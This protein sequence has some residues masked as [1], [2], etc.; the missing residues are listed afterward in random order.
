MDELIE[1][2]KREEFTEIKYISSLNPP[3]KEQVDDFMLESK[4]LS[5]SDK[6]NH[7]IEINLTDEL[8]TKKEVCLVVTGSVDSGKCFKLGTQVM[9]YNGIIEKVE[10]LKIGDLLM[11]DDSTPRKIL[12][13]HKGMGQLYK[14]I[15]F[16]GKEYVVNGE[17]ILCLRYKELNK[18]EFLE[19][20]NI[21]E[22]SVKEFLKLKK[23]E[24][25][26]LKW[27]KTDIEFPKKDVPFEAYK[28]GILLGNS[29][30]IK[31]KGIINSE[32]K[33]KNIPDIYKYNSKE[34]RLKL[35]AGLIDSD[36]YYNK[37]KNKYSFSILSKYKKLINDTIWLIRS[38]GLSIY[39]YN[40]K[41]I[42]I[43]TKNGFI[44]MSY[45]QFDFGGEKQETI[46]CMLFRKRAFKRINKKSNLESKI[47]IKKVEIGEYIGFSLDRNKRFLLEDFSVSHNSSFIGVITSGELDDGKG[48]ARAKVAKH[49]HEVKEGKTS[50]I[51]T[52]TI[53]LNGNIV[54][55]V[56]LC[57]HEKYL[58]TTL[59]GITGFYPDYGVLI[60]SANRGLLRMT[61][62][63]M[64]ILLYLKIPFIILITRIDIT[65]KNIYE[66]VLQN[67]SKILRKFK[68]EPEIINSL[69]DLD[70]N[71]D[72]LKE[73][74][75]ECFNLTEKIAKRMKTNHFIVPIITIS[76]KTGYFVEVVKHI[77]S[78][79][80]SRKI[81]NSISNGSIF[82]IDSKF[83]P[84]GIGLVISGLTKG[85]PIKVNT[86]MLI[87]PYGSEFK[88]IKIWSLHDNNKQ[89]VISLKDRQRGC[90]AIRSLDKKDEITRYNI[91]KG[92]IVISKEM[93]QNICYQFEA[94]IE[95]LN[96]STVISKRYT[97]V[98][99][100]GVVRQSA[101]I[102]LAEG[103]VLKMGDKAIISF[104][105][106]QNPE[107]IEK[108]SF[109]FFREGT[110]RGVG[111]IKSII[112]I[113]DDPDQT[114]A[115]PK[116]KIR[117]HRKN[118]KLNMT[119]DKRLSRIIKKNNIEII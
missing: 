17:H 101:R 41:S 70:L 25:N 81:W 4:I 20:G 68:R 99:H 62:E 53:N 11:G 96:H 109:F 6:C 49:P 67:T 94:E 72:L 113:K 12:E 24:Q 88:K 57:G 64:G 23:N 90:L 55:L 27:Y 100:C 118:R 44:K 16:K 110:T 29:K 104:R 79:F 73:R 5:K 10:N 34:I 71:D 65:P 52:R 42:L 13:I 47:K 102:I 97:P 40:K 39:K 80:E 69:S 103:Q 105:F 14:I 117:H 59:Y 45:Y 75:R 107:F 93:E 98:I 9:K 85:N 36:G 43:K 66:N 31:Q 60:I 32:I 63:H 56:D 91:R 26:M 28:L 3:K 2:N 84:T 92:M 77:F 21:K 18:E 76:S 114:S 33:N 108:D 19:N 54:T 50:D 7:N 78:K 51:S 35:L 38:L 86:E 115:N 116:R 82:Y 111:L 58:K 46:P 22:I 15:P 74:E 48:Y 1:M 30:S 61:K 112:P 89:T 37:G 119:N 8:E 87:G 106:V 83:S 95:I